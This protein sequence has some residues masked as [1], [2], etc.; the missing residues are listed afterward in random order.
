LSTK[1]DDDRD[2]GSTKNTRGRAPS[3]PKEMIEIFFETTHNQQLK[4]KRR[5]LG[6]TMSID[7]CDYTIGSWFLTAWDET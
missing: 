5:L 4:E 3:R 2:D 6:F 1:A 7:L